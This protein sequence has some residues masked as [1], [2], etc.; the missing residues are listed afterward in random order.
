MGAL[1]YEG[2]IRPTYED[3]VKRRIERAK[4]LFGEDVNTGE[5]TWLGKHIRLG[6]YDLAT[7]YEDMELIYLSFNPDKATGHAL[8]SVCVLGQIKRNPAIRASYIVRFT[9]NP[10]MVV[11]A[12]FLVATVD[13]VVFHTLYDM[14]LDDAG[15]GSVEVLCT[16]A[17]VVGNVGAGSINSIVNPAVGVDAV[18]GVAQNIV[19]EEA[20]SDASLRKRLKIALKGVGSAT[21]EAIMGAVMR[22]GGVKGCDLVENDTDEV[23]EENRPPRSFEVYALAPKEQAQEIAEAIF[24]KKPV[25]IKTAGSEERV[26]T[27]KGG[28]EHKVKFSWVKEKPIFAKLFVMKGQTFTA[29]GQTEIKNNLSEKIAQ[30]ASGADVVLSSLYGCVYKVSGVEDVA[31]IKLSTDGVNYAVSN[32]TCAFDEVA[33]LPIDNIVLEVGDYVDQ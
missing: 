17:G 29:T 9:G 22:V 30:L 14:T 15:E 19:G 16:E 10:K 4:K 1:T 24:S 20:E 8:D 12:G 6:A 33:R 31:S 28:H 21:R 23:D 18:D 5:K 2:F 25:G 32:I 7:A 27:D 3:L 26:V 11:P 13:N